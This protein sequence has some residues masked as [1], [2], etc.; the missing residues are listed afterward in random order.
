LL[1][2]AGLLSIVLGLTAALVVAANVEGISEI[3]ARSHADLF[4]RP[5]FSGK[6]P[7]A[8]AAA[9]AGATIIGGAFW[10]LLFF[11]LAA[12]LSELRRQQRSAGVA[13]IVVDQA[14]DGALTNLAMALAAAERRGD[15]ARV[16]LL[17]REIA[18]L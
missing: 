10:G 15:T 2:T 17:R 13:P 5:Y 4:G 1:R 11:G 6:L 3:A 18:S 8:F 16:A 14:T 9:L 12:V 7:R